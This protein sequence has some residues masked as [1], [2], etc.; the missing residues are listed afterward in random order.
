MSENSDSFVII[1]SEETGA[2]SYANQ[3]QLVQNVKPAELMKLL[4]ALELEN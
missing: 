2:I 4:P 3:G 1:V